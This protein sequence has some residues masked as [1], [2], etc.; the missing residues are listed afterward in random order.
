MHTISVSNECDKTITDG[1][2][3]NPSLR[4]QSFYCHYVSSGNNNDPII[5]LMQ[6]SEDNV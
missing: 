1:K 4:Y 6:E 5:L 2:E 3:A